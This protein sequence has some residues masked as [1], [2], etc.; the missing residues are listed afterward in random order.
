MHR[1]LSQD[2]YWA[3]GRPREVVEKTI[4]GVVGVVGLRV[5]TAQQVAF[6]RAVTDGLTFA[7][8]CD[9]YVDPAHR[10]HGLA[11]WAHAPKPWRTCAAA[12]VDRLVLATSSAHAVYRRVGFTVPAEGRYMELDDRGMTPPAPRTPGERGRGPLAQDLR[13]PR[14]CRA[15][16]DPL[17]VALILAW[18]GLVLLAASVPV[19]D[20][21]EL[22]ASARPRR[23][24]LGRPRRPAPAG[25]A[26]GARAD[27]RRRRARDLRGV[28]VLAAA[29][30]VHLPDR[31]GSALRASRARP[32][33][34][35]RADARPQRAG[36]PLPAAA[37][38]C[39]RARRRR[40]GGRRPAGCSAAGTTSS[41]PSGSP[42]CWGSWRGARTGGS[43]SARSSSC[44]TSNWRARR[45]G[46]GRWAPTDPVLHVIGQG[47]P[48]SGAAGGYGWFDLWALLLAPWLLATVCA[49]VDARRLR[50]RGVTVRSG[51]K[52]PSTASC[53]G[54][55]W[56]RRRRRT[57]RRPPPA[58]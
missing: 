45:S 41:A 56:R 16:L 51:A 15:H 20:G 5:R 48:P 39:D 29:P 49:V 36:R 23:R 24:H 58:R 26:A 53:R 12:G 33:L 6:L 42:A 7:W 17:A 13:A 38:R 3:L 4:D 27:A 43:T 18:I 30:G 35:R 40:L 37:R 21:G 44:P 57:G 32:G 19:P 31:H 52:T 55:L 8:I 2:A 11:T 9:V 10:G 14:A 22:G 46:C 25:D 50:P 1:W 47:N 28:H 54:P 34:P